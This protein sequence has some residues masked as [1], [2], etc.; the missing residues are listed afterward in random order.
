MSTS[1]YES[2]FDGGAVDSVGIQPRVTVNK[3]KRK[4]EDSFDDEWSNDP[5][6]YPPQP[7]PDGDDPTEITESWDVRIR[8]TV[9]H[10]SVA[11]LLV[12]SL[13]LCG[14]VYRSYYDSST[15]TRI[16]LA[17]QAKHAMRNAKAHPHGHLILP[18]R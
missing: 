4:P 11:G 10:S 9:R 14:C 5:V 17:A 15:N 1:G 6:G 12:Y 7:T 18:R 3:I 2:E 16:D 13:Y 8:Q